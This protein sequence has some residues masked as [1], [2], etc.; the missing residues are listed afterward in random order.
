MD[1]SVGEWVGIVGAVFAALPVV[2][3]AYQYINIRKA[4]DRGRQFSNYHGIVQSLVE[5]GT[6]ID[7]QTAAVF[8]LRNYP[9]YY[10]TTFRMLNRLRDAW[11]KSAN[12]S[13]PPVLQEMD[14]TIDFIK[15]SGHKYIE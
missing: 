4:E 3:G 6:Y 15:K 1:L 14:L 8:E 12:V 7:R 5:T 13:I 11:S 2:W 9:L 10:P